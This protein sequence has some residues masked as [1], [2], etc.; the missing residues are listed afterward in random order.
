MIQVISSFNADTIIGSYRDIIW[1]SNEE[2]VVS[3]IVHECLAII[4]SENYLI[5]VDACKP[6]FIAQ[7]L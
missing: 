4:V 3:S 7:Y 6:I 2:L 1:I 5:L